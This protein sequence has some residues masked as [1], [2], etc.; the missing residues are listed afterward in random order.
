MSKF[1]IAISK[2]VFSVSGMVSPFSLYLGPPMRPP[3]QQHGFPSSAG[4]PDGPSVEGT[5]APTEAPMFGFA[6]NNYP[7]MAQM[8]SLPCFKF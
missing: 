4:R 7:V 1:F 5:A 3:T 6:W 8:T 2:A